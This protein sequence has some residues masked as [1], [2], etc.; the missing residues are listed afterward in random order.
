MDENGLPI[1]GAGVDYTAVEAIN[2][3]QFV[4]F[5]NTF[6]VRSLSFIN[7]FSSQC[8]L[9]LSHLELRLEKVETA[10]MLLET[11]VNLEESMNLD[12]SILMYVHFEA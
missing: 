4:N 6:F 12:N 5:L 2:Q 7:N 1:I 9:K 11:K 8:D 3:R 10:L